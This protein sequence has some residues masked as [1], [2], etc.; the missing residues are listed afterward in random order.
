MV[1]STEKLYSPVSE[2]TYRVTGLVASLS[3]LHAERVGDESFRRLCWIVQVSARQSRAG[4]IQFSGHTGRHRLQ[5]LV[6]N[7]SAR[8]GDGPANRHRCGLFI[9]LIVIDS[10]RQHS[11]RCFGWSV[12][13]DHFASALSRADQLQH[14]MG[15]S[16]AAHYQSASRKQPKLIACTQQRLEM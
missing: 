12:V 10:A 2:V 4:Q 14:I 8:V 7:V 6:Q 3:G 9:V 15:K 13:I 5:L 16:F 11:N 1:Q